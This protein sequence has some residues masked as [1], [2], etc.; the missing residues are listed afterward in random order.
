MQNYDPGSYPA[1]SVGRI[2]DARGALNESGVDHNLIPGAQTIL[3]VV[4]R[5]WDDFWHE[6]E[7]LE[8]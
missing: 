7:E 8:E 6:P 1:D 5:D 4:L 3:K 2:R